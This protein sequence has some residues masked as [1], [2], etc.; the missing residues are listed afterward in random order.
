VAARDADAL[1]ALY[2]DESETLDHTTG[3]TW[4]REAQLHTISLLLRA[5]EPTCRLEPLATLGDLLA[6]FRVST[7]ASRFVGGTFDVGAYQKEEIH[8]VEVDARGRCLG[9]EGFAVDQLGNA[10]GLARQ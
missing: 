3:T 9:G 5:E 1:P 7:S 6:L 10:V 4:R 8:L 2:A